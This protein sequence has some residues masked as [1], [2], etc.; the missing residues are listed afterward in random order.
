MHLLRPKQIAVCLLAFVSIAT[1]GQNCMGTQRVDA[2]YELEQN[3]VC[4]GIE[5]TVRNTSQLFGNTSTF[6]IWDWG[7]GTKD[8][9]LD[10][11]SVR[12][13]YVFTDQNVCEEGLAIKELRLDAKVPGC[14]QYNHF[15]IKPVYVF[16]KPQ[17]K[18]K[19]DSMLCVPDTIASFKNNSCTADTGV[20]YSWNFGDPVSGANNTSDLFEPM[21]AFSGPGTYVVT[22]DVTSTCGSGSF[23]NII[24]VKAPPKVAAEADVPAGAGCVPVIVN[25]HNQTTGANSFSWSVSPSNGALF[26]DSTSSTSWEPRIL[27]TKAGTY[28]IKLSAENEC[29]T[30]NWEKMVTISEPPTVNWEEPPVGCENL[31][32]SPTITYGGTISTYNWTFEGGNPSTSTD[33]K[34]TNI[35]FSTPGKYNVTLTVNGA[36]GSQSFIKTVEVIPREAITFTPVAPLCTTSDTVHLGVNLPGG[37]WSGQG[38]NSQGVFNPATANVGTNTIQ[39]QYGPNNCR[40]EGSLDIL[41]RAG[42]PLDVGNDLSI[43]NDKDDITLP[44]LPSGGAWSG[45]GIVDSLQGIFSPRQAGVGAQTLTYRY[46]ESTNGCITTAKKIVR[47]EPVPTVNIAETTVSFCPFN[48]DIKLPQELN[49]QVNPGGGTNNWT[50]TGI[51]D[52]TQGIFNNSNLGIGS[53]PILYT[54][55]S[56]AGCVASDSLT[57]QIIP[58]QVAVTQADTT[59]CISAGSLALN[60]TPAGGK[61]SGTQ[62]DANSGTIDLARAGG[63]TKTYTYTIF[64]GSTCEASDQVSLNIIDLSGVNAGQDTGYC[65]SENQVTLSGFSPGGGTWSGPGVIDPVQGIVDIQALAPGDYTLTYQVKSN[66]AVACAAEDQVVLTVHPLPQVGFNIGG[67]NC[68]GTPIAFTN[69]ATNTATYDW[70]F[71]NGQTSTLENPSV[72]YDTAGDYTLKFVTKSSF[73]CQSDTSLVIH[74][75][76]PP[77]V[78]SFDMDQRSGC[79]DLVVTFRN[80][81]QGEDVDFAWNFG[82]GQ[83]DSIS[84]PLPITFLGNLED[85]TYFVQ[86]SARN[87]CGENIFRDSVRVFSRPTA[88]FGTRLNK[89]C[90]GD[91]V[92]I[93]NAS[94]GRPTAYFWNFGN[95]LTSR[96]SVPETQYYFTNNEPDTFKIT[97]IASNTCAADTMIRLVPINPTNVKAFFNLDATDIC[98]GDTIRIHNFST[99]GAAVTYTFGDQNTSATPNPAHVYSEPGR[100]KII[101]YAR[102]CGFDS[103]FAFVNVKPTPTILLNLDEFS[104]DKAELHFRYTASDIVGTLWDFGDG[105][106]STLPSPTHLYD[107]SGTYT[108]RLTATD[109]NQCRSLVEQKIDI[110]PLPEFTLRIPDSLCVREKGIFEVIPTSINLSSYSWQYGDQEQGS[111]RATQHQFS[112]SGIFNVQATVTDIYGCKNV[113]SRPIFVRPGPDAAFSFTYLNNCAPSGIA[114]VNESKTANSYH[115]E[116]GDGNSADITNPTNTYYQGG[117]YEAR[118]IASYDDI[119]FDTLTRTIPINAI[120]KAIVQTEDLTCHGKDDGRIRVIPNGSHTV[121]VTGE[122]YFQE[123]GNLFEALKPGTY[124]INVV[125]AS[126]CDTVYTVDIH[127][128][129]TL[130]AYIQPD[131]IPLIVGDT[132]LIQVISNNADIQLQWLPESELTQLDVSTFS[133]S[134]RRSLW[135]NLVGTLGTCVLRDSVFIA[136]DANRKVY[137][138][139]AFSPNGDNV[140]DFFYIHGGAG[141]EQIEQ[142]FIFER[143]GNLVFEQTNIDPNDPTKGWDGTFQGR[144]MNPAVFVYLAKI[145]FIDGETEIFSGDVTLVR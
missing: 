10:L 12:H 116:F 11:S 30:V 77:P 79:A 87:I 6:F 135:Y 44:F 96:D 22:L 103:T 100:Y 69:T 104:C 142:F 114:F 25:M 67:K 21:H 41:V 97:L 86:L 54:Y 93:Q 9:T 4:E 80:R 118:L 1:Y 3:D 68:I 36:C 133:T 24:E 143:R 56:P 130:F 29:G 109:A 126:G 121:I 37:T 108:V 92:E 112:Q 102:S 88:N 66:A 76:E 26:V 40:S 46:V 82:N 75:S 136:V 78:V 53:Y 35:T 13:T 117:E 55:T 131:T 7:D 111:G 52:A 33:P 17:A 115:W 15:V 64:G 60:A 47:V 99:P 2:S 58:K 144:K 57:I 39:Y 129:D 59:V 34:P 95:G 139:N 85:T 107:S 8:T 43:C 141:I 65:E 110:L 81:S 90:S 89:Y 124:D 125:A 50:G 101:Q 18:F 14:P 83:T 27:F 119:C 132:A 45:N 31:V 123:G 127:E 42:T 106:T 28:T 32:Y 145:K 70:N 71:G 140:N 138:P 72:T 94:F 63:G 91:A 120:P 84:N 62:I 49:V 128:P 61:W 122:D 134:T 74:V 20:V 137:I 73:G 19:M 51:T 16:L 48:G 5:I 38:V 23:S 113:E 105:S 98:V